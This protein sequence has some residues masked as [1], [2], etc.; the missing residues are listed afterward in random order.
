VS[1]KEVATRAAVLSALADA[2]GDELKAAKAELQAELKAA[3]ETT[4]TQQVGV[5]LPDGQDVGKIS[6]VQ[7][8][9]TATVTDDKA[10]LEWARKV[11]PSEVVSRVVTEVRSSWLKLALAEMTAAGVAQWCDKETGELHAVPGVEIQGRAAYTRMTLPDDGKAAIA[12]AWRTRKLDH[13]NLLQLPQGEV[14]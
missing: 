4:G 11:R 5:S 14:A 12:E 13:L 6:L 8:K 7:P 9:A 10:F 1:L 2:I 3:K